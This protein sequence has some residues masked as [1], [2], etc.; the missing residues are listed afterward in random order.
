[1]KKLS[2]VVPI[3]N[4]EKL[5]SKTIE[6][7]VSEKSDEIEIILL[8][9]GSTDGTLNILREYEKKDSRIV[10][11]DKK[12]SDV[13]DTRNRGIKEAKGK[14]I[15]FIDADDYLEPNYYSVV[16]KYLVLDNKKNN[17]YDWIVFCSN[18]D[19]SK[20]S[21]KN[22]FEGIA[23]LDYKYTNLYLG[24]VWSKIYRKEF[25]VNNKLYFEDDISRHG[26]DI[27]YNLQLLTFNPKVKVTNEHIYNYRVNFGSS[28]MQIFIEEETKSYRNYLFDLKPN[29]TKSIDYMIERIDIYTT[30]STFDACSRIKNK[31]ERK[32]KLEEFLNRDYVIKAISN[33]SNHQLEP[34]RNR[35]YAKL[36]IKKKYNLLLFLMKIKNLIKRKYIF[37]KGERIYK[38]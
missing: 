4:T 36:I 17:Q 9:D 10:V 32:E 33:I 21:R 11:I 6:S 8:N 27:L 28:T 12:N 2:I 26:E 19:G 31:K 25:I 18:Y 14:Y 1:M 3:Y 37:R 13:S 38:V 29:L 24:V 23:S 22:L 15:M 30:I 7:I 5:I 16:S 34:K 35:T 20:I